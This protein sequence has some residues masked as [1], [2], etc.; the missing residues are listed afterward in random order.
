MFNEQKPSGRE[1]LE[2]GLKNI[3]RW[4]GM[5]CQAMSAF[6]KLCNGTRMDSVQ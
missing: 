3:S 4:A 1:A 5:G 6:A 2:H